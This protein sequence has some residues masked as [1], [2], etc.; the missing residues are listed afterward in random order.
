MSVILCA[1][2]SLAK[3]THRNSS[4]NIPLFLLVIVVF[5]EPS[6]HIPHAMKDPPYVDVVITLDIEDQMG[7]AA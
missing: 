3:A 1:R 4:K 7:I 6:R 2:T 5:S